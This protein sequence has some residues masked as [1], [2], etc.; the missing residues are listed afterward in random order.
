MARPIKNLHLNEL[1]RN[2]LRCSVPPQ[3]ATQPLRAASFVPSG[4]PK[5]VHASHPLFAAYAPL[6]PLVMSRKSRC[7]LIKQG[8]EKSHRLASTLVDQRNQC[9]PQR[10]DGARSA[11][12]SRLAIDE[13]VVPGARVGIA[14]NIRHTP[15]YAM[16]RIRR[17]RHARIVLPGRQR[18]YIAHSATGGA[19]ICRQIVPHHFTADR[20]RRARQIACRR[21]PARS[22][23]KPG[24]PRGFA[25]RVTPSVD[26][27]SP[28]ATHTVIPIA[29]ARLKCI[30]H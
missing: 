7:T 27:L 24:S 10:C 19:F 5:P 2:L 30:I 6:L 16:I 22:D 23:S 29:P 8:I 17:W 9:R 11:D 12:R 13:D 28:H 25:R 15:S 4:E 26:P 1:R 18:K 21:R 20:I 14:R 3:I